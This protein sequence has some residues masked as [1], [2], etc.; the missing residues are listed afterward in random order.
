MLRKFALSFVAGVFLFSSVVYGQQKAATTAV[1]HGHAEH[2][3]NDGELL[4]VGKEEYHVELLV[5]ESK[6][7]MTIYLLD[8]EIKDYVAIDT[9]HL[10]VNFLLAGKPTQVKLIPAPQELDKKGFSSRFSVVSPTLFAGLHSAKA[11]PKLSLRIQNK[12]YS[13]KF[14]HD[15]DHSG[16][17]HSGH[18]Q[19]AAI[20]AVQPKKR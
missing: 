10:A 9:P 4:E 15:H 8:K 6:K 3:P 16:H 12:S 5:D 17:D 19:A 14:S 2:G 1:E 18:K 11:D 20:K 13:V 7:Q